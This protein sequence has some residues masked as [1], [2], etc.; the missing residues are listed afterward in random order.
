MVELVES[1]RYCRYFENGKCTIHNDIFENK[2]NVNDIVDYVI[3]DG[4]ISE[5]L[6]EVLERL[7]LSDYDKEN[8]IDDIEHIIK[9]T[10]YEEPSESGFELV[11]PW[12]FKCNK[13]I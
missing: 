7:N 13:Y 8:L 2:N 6:N 5:K 12:D 4:I 10:I 11:A 1:C 9:N 3:G